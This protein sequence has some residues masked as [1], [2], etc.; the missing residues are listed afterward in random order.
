M[1]RARTGQTIWEIT[2][3]FGMTAGDHRLTFGTHGELIDLVDYASEVP[4]G[5]WSF[6][7]LDSLAAGRASSYIGDIPTAGAR[8]AFRIEQIGV[9]LQDQWGPTPRL[10]VTA[11]LRLDV[12]FVPT[13]PT[14]NE[15]AL[16]WGSTLRSPRAA[17]L[18]GL[19]GWA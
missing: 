16:N 4:G 9:Y 15:A 10:T 12:P 19:P 3:N 6:D 14:Q 5:E 17:T 7:D 13:L 1:P 2:D 18:S 8:V 11:G